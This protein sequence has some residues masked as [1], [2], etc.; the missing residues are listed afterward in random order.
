MLEDPHYA[1]REALIEVD[2]ARWGKVTMQNV[3]PKLSGTPGGVRW[4][5]P[6]RLGEHTDEVLGDLLDMTSEQI[7]Q[8]RQQGVV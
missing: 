1:A 7:E 6:D 2:S 3:T 4:P 8:L 5:G